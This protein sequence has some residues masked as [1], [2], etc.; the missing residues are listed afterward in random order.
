[1]KNTEINFAASKAENAL[2]MK[3]AERAMG[4]AG[5]RE[6]SWIERGEETGRM[7]RQ[8]TS[9]ADIMMDVT[10]THLNGNPLRLEALL[11]ADDFNF[12]HDIYGIRRHLDRTTGQ[13]K[14][15]FSPRFSA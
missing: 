9:A 14:D 8:R 7:K 1:M 5:I 12:A 3:I 15:F 10:S 6:E 13:L 2:I 11:E 4:L